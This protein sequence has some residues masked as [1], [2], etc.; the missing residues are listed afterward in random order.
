MLIN[1]LTFGIR[2]LLMQF[3]LF[4]CLSRSPYKSSM[5]DIVEIH[6]F[7][8][9]N[10][11]SYCFNQISFQYSLLTETNLNLVI[12]FCEKCETRGILIDFNLSG[13]YVMN[14]Y[15]I[16]KCLKTLEKVRRVP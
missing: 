6:T 5:V 8:S 10:S 14:N 1:Y 16:R 15:G 3:R 12:Y 7:Q 11:S 2:V 9:L 4:A 13:Y